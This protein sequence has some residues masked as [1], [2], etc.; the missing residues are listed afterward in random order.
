MRWIY[1][2]ALQIRPLFWKHQVEHE[3]SDELRFYLEKLIE[4]KATKGMAPE[5]ARFAALRELGGLE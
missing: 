5:E 2:L 3:L 1:K 4:E